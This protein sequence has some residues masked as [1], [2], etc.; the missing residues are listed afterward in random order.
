MLAEIRRS[1]PHNEYVL[2]WCV[3]EN[4]MLKEVRFVVCSH[5]FYVPAQS[6]LVVE[7]CSGI[8]DALTK[9]KTE[10]VILNLSYPD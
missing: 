10:S 8:H 4:H 6:H 3:I 9:G 7:H 1:R 5:E 2:I